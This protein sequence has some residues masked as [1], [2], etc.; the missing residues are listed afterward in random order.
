MLESGTKLIQINM[1]YYTLVLRA[2]VFSKIDAKFDLKY[3][4]RNIHHSKTCSR[5][6]IIQ[7]SFMVRLSLFCY[8]YLGLK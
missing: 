5:D 7:Y 4:E 8:A 6:L 1:N 3:K 2:E